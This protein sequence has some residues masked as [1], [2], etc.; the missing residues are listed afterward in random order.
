MR[1]LIRSLV[2]VIFFVTTFQL[3]AQT[4]EEKLHSFEVQSADLDGQT[5]ISIEETNQKLKDLNAQLEFLYSQVSLFHG[6]GAS[7]DCYK[8]LVQQI[9]SV[10][11]SIKWT[12]DDWRTKSKELCPEENF[13]LC[14]QPDTTLEQLIIDYGSADYVYLIPPEVSKMR[15]SVD[16]HLAIP[17]EAWNEMIELI[18]ANSGLG[19]RQ[20]N[21]FLRQ[22]YILNQ[23]PLGL[24]AILTKREDLCLYPDH[25]RVC[26]AIITKSED[27]IEI[28]H[29]LNRFTQNS[30]RIKIHLIG[31]AFFILAQVQ[32]VK[33]ILDLYDF[34]EE[35][36]DHKEHKL[37]QLHRISSD[38]MRGILQAYFHQDAE[39]NSPSSGSELQIVP[40]QAT[41][42]ALFLI[43]SKSQVC[44]A[45]RIICDIEQRL[46]DPKEK[47]I[48]WYTCK[49]AQANV[50]AE[51]LE[52]V[53]LLI[54]NTPC[55]ELP[56]PPPEA[57]LVVVS[58]N[59]CG[60]CLGVEGPPLVVATPPV[61]PPPYC[62]AQIGPGPCSN[63]IVD[64]KSGAI[65]MVIEND[66]L[67]KIKEII[68]K[69]DQPAKM[70]QIEVLLFEKKIHDQ[71]NFGLNLFKI[72][73]Q[74]SNTQQ[75]S[76]IWNDASPGPL[77]QGILSFFLSRM[78]GGGLPAYDLVYNFMLTQD[79]V[80]I[81]ACPSVT[82]VNQTC[83]KIALVEEI[84]INNGA[85]GFDCN[86]TCFMKDSYSRAQFGIT[87][88]ITPT[89]HFPDLCELD[90]CED[91]TPYITLDTNIIFD[92]AKPSPVSRP[93]VTRRNIVNQVRVPDG[94]TVIIGGLRRK[95]SHDCAEKIPFLGEIP[96]IGRFF[97]FTKLSDSQT[98][99]FI[100][101]TPK[102]IADPVF[103][104]H[105]LRCEEMC[106]RPGDTPAFLQCVLEATE[107]ERTRVLAGSLR[108][109][110]G[111]GNDCSTGCFIPCNTFEGY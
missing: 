68:K 94:Q 60:P 67:P 51:I 8:D 79:D 84:S 102:I 22:V 96:G 104:F 9:K 56:I 80:Q 16:S 91:P 6:S 63:F 38:E 64:Q 66:Y 25:A 81:N 90:P 86:N 58:D 49:H 109:L 44:R 30:Q 74:A 4:L 46:E 65:I 95:M 33:E 7:S 110:F 73:S 83:A 87:I 17:K 32:E 76:L 45:E 71:S 1:K 10:K 93:D 21:P 61:F 37:I 48:Y 52:R 36:E 111:R 23:E 19:I 101:I 29:F 42:Q 98:E 88:E 59:N 3:F 99:M 26:F 70:V 14:H 105:R 89:I 77:N 107:F 11:Q 39:P 108:M 55:V 27:P 5:I 34:V 28:F 100:F 82:T 97:S 43:G 54:T 41:S 35:N 69:L 47:T 78:R 13:S 40:I 2:V 15:V 92:S 18:L 31:R 57:P 103:D 72:G 24:S 53:Y 106:K 62:N 20:L 12:L 75:T 85:V 50:V